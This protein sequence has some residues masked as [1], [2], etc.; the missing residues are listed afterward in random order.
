[1][2]RPKE[3]FGGS[4]TTNLTPSLTRLLLPSEDG[5]G[6]PHCYRFANPAEAFVG[7]LPCGHV[8]SDVSGLLEFYHCLALACVVPC[9]RNIVVFYG[10]LKVFGAVM[11]PFR[12][13]LEAV[14][15]RL[16]L[17]WDLVGTISAPYCVT[18]L[19]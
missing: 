7:L 15:G 8:R 12:S 6:R 11:E 14:L 1:M 5:G 18:V 13:R 4:G 19:V 10:F 16:G 3:P 9:W 2:S 17:S